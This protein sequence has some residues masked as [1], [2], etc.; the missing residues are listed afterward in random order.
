MHLVRT[1]LSPTAKKTGP[2]PQNG[3]RTLVST[4]NTIEYLN[5][6]FRRATRQRGHFPTEQVVLKILYPTTQEK[7]PGRKNLTGKIPNWKHI[8]N[9]LT[10]HYPDQL[11]PNP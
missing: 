10:I 7:R 2:K 6:R 1:N 5:A 3:L 9:I 8:L 11:T 4:I